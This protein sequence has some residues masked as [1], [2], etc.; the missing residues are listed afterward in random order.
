MANKTYTTG[1]IITGNSTGGVKAIKA[2]REQLEQLNASQK[3][4][5][6]HSRDFGTAAN[7]SFLSIS[8]SAL[9]A[10]AGIAGV[11]VGIRSLVN[12]FQYVLE[13]GEKYERQ[14]LRTE[15]LVKSTAGAA[16]LSS[17]ALGELAD[18][19]ALNTLQSV[20]GVSKAINIMQTF[21]S[22]TGDTFKQS[23]AL[24]ADLATVMGGDITSS[25]LQLGKALEDPVKGIT[26][27]SRSGVS[28]TESQKELIKS[29][30]E[31]GEKAEAQRII[32]AELEKQVGG[33]GEAESKGLSGSYDTLGQKVDELA[34]SFGRATDA[35]GLWKD[36]IDQMARGVGEA[37]KIIDENF[38][39]DAA[40]SYFNK[41][42]ELQIKIQSLEESGTA[43][44]IAQA[45][46]LRQERVKLLELLGDE[47][48]ASNERA[49]L[50]ASEHQVLVARKKVMDAVVT[51]TKT[52]TEE[53][54]ARKRELEA[55][56]ASN[57][58]LVETLKF[59]NKALLLSDKERY[60][61][62]NLRKLNAD[63][64]AE[65]VKQVR[66]L[67]SSLFDQKTGAESA[68]KAQDDYV[69][70]WKN[71]GERVAST[72]QNAIATDDW[73]G[74]GTTVGG[75]FAG[76]LAGLVTDSLV[77]TLGSDEFGAML[78][79]VLGGVAG[80][81]A[82]LAISELSDYFS[83]DDLDPTAQRQA[84]QGTG[85][86][87]A[88][89][90]EKSA[91][92]AKATDLTAD[93]TGEIVSINKSML[94]AL[95]SL[96]TG[97]SGVVAQ[98]ARATGGISFSAPKVDTNLFDKNLIGKG[99][100][101][102]FDVIGSLFS[103]G[104]VN[105]LGELI[106]KALGGKSSKIDE[107]I[108]I[109]G[110]DIQSLV[111]GSV[112]DAFATFKT[113]KN[114]LDDYDVSNKF[115][116][117]GDEINDQFGLVFSGIIDSVSAG[118][119]ALG[120]TSSQIADRLNSVILDTQM[121]SLEGLDAAAQQAEIQAVFSKVFDDTVSAVV[122]YLAE[123]QRA[124]EGLGETLARVSTE[125]DL[126]QEAYASLGFKVSATFGDL[127][128]A[129]AVMGK[130]GDVMSGLPL[131]MELFVQAADDLISK[132]GG[133]EAFSSALSGF[134]RNFLSAEE[135]TVNLSRRLG[136]ALG[137]LPLPETRDG[138]KELLQAQDAM[139]E[140]GRNNIATLLQLQG[141][142]DQYYNAL[143]NAAK[144]AADSVAVVFDVI[145][146]NIEEAIIS[147]AE[148]NK[149]ALS[150]FD[151]KFAPSDVIREREIAKLTAAIA[152]S[153]LVLPDTREG[154][155]YL[156]ESLDITTEAGQRAVETLLSLQ[157]QANTYYSYLDDAAAAAAETANGIADAAAAAAGDAIS[158]FSKMLS[159][160]ADNTGDA[161]SRLRDSVEASK[162]SLRSAYSATVD[163]KNA[164]FSERLERIR[165]SSEE[166]IDGLKIAEDLRL[167]AANDALSAA[168]GGLSSIR[169]E[170]NAVSGALESLRAESLPK[171]MLRGQARSTL[172]AALSSGNYAG[173]GDAAEIAADIRSSD[174]ATAVDF[175][176]QQGQTRIL[177]EQ[178]EASGAIK[179]SAAERTVSMLEM[180]IE[181]IKSSS[182]AEVEA[183][184]D[185]R[186]F[187]LEKATAQHEAELETLQTIH[188][189]EMSELDSILKTA[190]RQLNA[191]R[192]VEYT[193][194]SISEE[195][196]RFSAAMKEEA[197]WQKMNQMDV[198]AMISSMS[199]HLPA[200]NDAGIDVPGFASGG[201]FGGGLRV[202]G[203]KG[204]ELEFTG[205]SRI[206]SN[207]DSRALFDSSA[208]V[209]ELRNLG[210]RLETLEQY[211]RQTTSNTAQSV[212]YAKRWDVDG[213]PPE[214][215][216]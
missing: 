52:L 148:K 110:G 37:T 89:I 184:I 58:L 158:A 83:G 216:A 118:A 10:A 18:D 16:G 68:A 195:M 121:I 198:A 24:S 51:T 28:F 172:T 197:M 204:P 173:V 7:N 181:E 104:L 142:A 1:L 209:G 56:I 151:S 143:E 210:R 122:P 124:G 9:G 174:Y 67:S 203:E 75:I 61:Q 25:A 135:Q 4:G 12:G 156:K 149:E 92:I 123:F 57:K 20:D 131:P 77:E 127:N 88:S 114:F 188:D 46:R 78:G 212:K 126:A 85:T 136:E 11:T 106:G 22:V 32:L 165:A 48:E 54:K 137:D 146:E 199:A 153:N 102:Q 154:F 187:W 76:S 23:I 70:S 34:L 36:F 93:A 132:T 2:T 69:K 134:E 60:I 183:A 157:G 96:E 86:I 105:N 166:Y 119:D 168:K 82:A 90:N 43:R 6:K 138:F 215:V 29:L 125:F 55:N 74:L 214:R 155:Y 192:G 49:K 161:I 193:V 164:G 205:P 116:T 107:G 202:V 39:V 103:L 33:V 190:D 159:I 15:A 64:T 99:I 72:L 207:N 62:I 176:R 101:T 30:S 8:K 113:R 177:L 100:E 84:A 147:F 47:V 129:L 3:S 59:E 201:S 150:S 112:V 179:E 79:P 38:N 81:I 191:L 50:A 144:D 80:G 5:A 14:Q 185:A 171:E 182:A 169:A 73:S 213:M 208:I 45:N 141:A 163:D 178:L 31:T 152:E 115:A 196:A 87:L 194:G 140:G 27:L 175:A 91:S 139:S 42:L 186:D 26:A 206:M 17:K 211:T 40:T 97:I 160:A 53:E 35:G 117:L 21:R 98:T 130:V 44:S 128:P 200:M 111:E 94:T 19:V 65:E 189:A 66:K 145:V 41:S 120:I 109:L 108:R 71:A 95:K 133:I 170:I 180:Q 167:E 162:D 63:A 13:V